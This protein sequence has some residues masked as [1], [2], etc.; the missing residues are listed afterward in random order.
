M[1]ETAAMD[2]Y[3]YGRGSL[4]KNTVLI[5]ALSADP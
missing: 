2:V 1:V 4:C 5:S 3:P